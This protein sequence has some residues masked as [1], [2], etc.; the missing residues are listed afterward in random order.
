MFDLVEGSA[1]RPADEGA[2][3]SKVD[4]ECVGG[5]EEHPRGERR[6]RSVVVA[7]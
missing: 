6:R 4:A 3:E 5:D 7:C 2:W 1:D